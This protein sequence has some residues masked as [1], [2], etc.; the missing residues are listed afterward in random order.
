MGGVGKTQIALEY[1]YRYHIEYKVIWWVGADTN[2]TLLQ[3]ANEFIKRDAPK[4]RKNTSEDI[5]SLFRHWFENNPNWMIIY[6]N[7]DDFEL[8]VPYLP[9]KMN[10]NII[11][12]TRLS[13]VSDIY[14]EMVDVDSLNKNTAIEFL[15]KRTK[16]QDKENAG[17]LADRLGYL[18]LALEQAGAYI[19]ETPNTDYVRYLSLLQNHDLDVLKQN[20]KITDYEQTIITTWVISANKIKERSALQLLYLCS[21]FAPDDIELY[22]FTNAAEYLCHPL[23]EEITNEL[24][25][26]NILR[27]LTKY[28]LVKYENEKLHVHRLLQEATRSQQN[29][30]GLDMA[31]RIIWEALPTAERDDLYYYANHNQ[32]DFIRYLSHAEFIAGF[33]M[34]TPQK[35]ERRLENIAN[36]YQIIATRLPCAKRL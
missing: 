5:A 33:A 13:N 4:K 8:I 6:D 36:I 1:V 12:T 28:S 2:E 35:T 31:L 29:N 22:F 32:E 27:E 16:I 34:N 17:L 25:R 3:S 18:P 15:E 7:V 14:G 26:D 9:K 10:G 23:K 19:R 21:Y 24:K 30:N 11:F 20:E